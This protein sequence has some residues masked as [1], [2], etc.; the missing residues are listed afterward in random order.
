MIL[1]SILYNIIIGLTIRKTA[2]FLDTK[3]P[4]EF[5]NIFLLQC[6]GILLVGVSLFF[7]LLLFPVLLVYL[8]LQLQ[9]LPDF[10]AC[11]HPNFLQA[12]CSRR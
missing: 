11:P 6:Y 12:M 5:R 10:L 3:I 1:L 7:A 2:S 4:R 8:I 9:I